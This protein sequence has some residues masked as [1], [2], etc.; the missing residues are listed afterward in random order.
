MKTMFATTAEALAGSLRELIANGTLTSGSRL[1]ERDLAE[2][3]SVSRIPMR[4]AIQLLKGEGIVEIYK[5]RGAIVRMLTPSDVAEI[6]GLR[7]LLEGDA[8][9]HAVKNMDRETVARIELAHRLLGE[10]ATREKQGELNREFHELLYAPCRNGRQL[11]SIRELRGQVERYE[12]LQS[13]LLADTQAFQDE[14]AEILQAC[15]AGDAKLARAMTV[16]HLETAKQIV[17]RLVEE[18][19]A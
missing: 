19:P 10:A 15:I 1:I 18:T 5:N 3:F 7:I 6:Y 11:K 12:R 4:E 14:H 13:T 2:R 17:A 16:K 9:Y 8:I